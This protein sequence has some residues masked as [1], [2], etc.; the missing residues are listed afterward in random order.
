MW[1]IP[2]QFYLPWFEHSNYMLRSTNYGFSHYII[3]YC[4]PICYPKIYIL[5]YTGL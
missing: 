3:F 2:R 5:R 4:L 1:H